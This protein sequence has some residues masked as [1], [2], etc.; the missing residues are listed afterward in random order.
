MEMWKNVF[1]QVLPKILKVI[2]EY[3]RS[4]AD[5]VL[6]NSCKKFDVDLDH[7][8]IDNLTEEQCRKVVLVSYYDILACLDTA[9]DFEDELNCDAYRNV[10][11]TFNMCFADNGLTQYTRPALD[12][13]E[14]KVVI[15]KYELF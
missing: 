9:L 15:N 10:M 6:R 8:E 12:I 11:I 5:E 7:I 4:D 14:Y 3:P 2:C 1:E 13:N